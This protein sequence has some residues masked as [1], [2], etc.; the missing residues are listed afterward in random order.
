M[1]NISRKEYDQAWYKKNKEKKVAKAKVWRKNNPDKT[2]KWSRK[3]ILRINFQLTE[4]E[5]D[6]KLQK[7]SGCCAICKKH[8][9]KLKLKLAV[10][11]DHATGQVRS[12]LCGNCNRG[13]GFFKDNSDFLQEAINYLLRFK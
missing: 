13:L 5:Y 3:R 4:E 6:Q 11:H 1:S 9:D 12:L 10:D 2:A 8:Q 7:Q